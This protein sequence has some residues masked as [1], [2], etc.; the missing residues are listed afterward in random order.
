MQSSPKGL[1]FLSA[2]NAILKE[3]LHPRIMEGKREPCE[4]AFSDFDGN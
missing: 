4:M 3:Q 2:G 1:I